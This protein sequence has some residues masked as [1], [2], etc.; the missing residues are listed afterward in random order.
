MIK[1]SPL[2]IVVLALL[3]SASAVAQTTISKADRDAAIDHLKSTQKE[4]FCKAIIFIM[5][6][7]A[8][9]D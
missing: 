1:L 6:L 2:F 7:K 8:S 4:L 9:L 5:H 3:M